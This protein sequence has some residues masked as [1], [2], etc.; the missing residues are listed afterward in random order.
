MFILNKTKEKLL[1][2]VRYLTDETLRLSKRIS[3]YRS[4]LRRKGDEIDAVHRQT[5]YKINGEPVPIIEV[6][7]AIVKHTGLE[8][9]I[10]PTKPAKVVLVAPVLRDREVGL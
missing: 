2:E 9:D 3:D 4:S 6:I 1:S 5:I 7:D 8:L 10:V